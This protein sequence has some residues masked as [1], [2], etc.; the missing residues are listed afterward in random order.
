[1]FIVL[2]VKKR[3]IISLTLITLALALLIQ[4]PL[5]A[6]RDKRKRSNEAEL[7]D[8]QQRE[9]ESTFTEGMK[10]F[11]LEDYSKS[12]GAF[13][14]ASELNPEEPMTYFKMAEIFAKSSNA[15]DQTRAAGNIERALKLNKKNKYFYLLAAEIYTNQNNF[16][17]AEEALETMTKEV[18]DTGEHLYQLAAIYQYDNKPDEAIKTYN[19]AE[20]VLG[21]N[22]ISSLQK[23]KLY[24][25]K[26]N[27]SYAIAEGEKLLKAYPDNDEYVIRFAETLAQKGQQKKAIEYTEKFLSTHPE[28]GSAKIF[29]SGLYRADGRETESRTMLKQAIADP[30][31]DVSQKVMVLQ[32]YVGQ[33]AQNKARNISDPDLQAF[34]L[35][36]YQ[37]LQTQYPDDPNVYVAGGNLH[38]SLGHKQEAQ[39]SFLSAVQKGSASFEA[40]QNLLALES[41][42]NQIDSLI[43]HSEQ[44][45]EIFPNQA[46]LYYF[47]GYGHLRKRSYRE[48]TTSLEQAKKLSSANPGLLHD[49]NGMLGE[50]YN[51]SKEFAKSDQA[52]EQALAYNPN[53]DFILNNYSYYLS[54][55]KE[56]LEKA[57]RMAEQVVKSHPE[58]A[59]YLDTYAWVLYS[60]EKYKEARKVMERALE[61][62]GTSAEHFEHYGDILFRLGDVDGAVKQ[63]ERARSLTS[64]HEL[65]DKKI[66]NRRLY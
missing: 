8:L 44:G 4:F 37:D 5:N 31:V 10:F 38:L 47:N 56:H 28:S 7:K 25:E 39:Q 26:G 59:T 46:M 12:L 20:A 34:A 51:G 60:R 48:A 32:T 3:K 53:D 14:R 19:R 65:I 50:S 55:R 58:N 16:F 52:Y 40:W 6:Q 15:D 64:Q 62:T 24:L 36:I 43:F 23:E 63:W 27:V 33:I 42:F 61:L 21:I 41:Q 66:A 49:I 45:L 17:K 18:A 2:L 35:V 11:I 30:S 1:M 9:A 54:L 29:L 22:E 13:Q 57:E